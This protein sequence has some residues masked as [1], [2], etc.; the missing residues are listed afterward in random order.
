[1]DAMNLILF[2]IIGAIAGW[3]AGMIMKGKGF[4]VIGNL[5]TGIVGAFLGRFL[6]G[7]IGL[8]AHGMIGRLIAATA[9][10]VV[11]VWVVNLIKKR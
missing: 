1:M 6:F 11:L 2:L 10:A 3:L 5:V 7:V 4:G 8:S 9:G